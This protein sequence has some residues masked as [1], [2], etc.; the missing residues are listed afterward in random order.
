MARKKSAEELAIEAEIAAAGKSK[1]ELNREASNKVKGTQQDAVPQYPS[2]AA[3]AASGE[4]A[5]ELDAA[6]SEATK[7]KKKMPKWLQSA[8]GRVIAGAVVVV[9]IVAFIGIAT[10]IRMNSTDVWDGTADTSWFKAGTTEYTFH[11]AEQLAGLSK[12]V[13]EG[14]DFDGVQFTL[15]NNIDLYDIPFQCI[16]SGLNN[17]G[18]T[19]KFA[20]SFDGGNHT[21]SGI[22]VEEDTWDHA[23]L[24]GLTDGGVLENLSVEGKVVGQV[25]VGGVVGEANGT[26]VRNCTSRC[27]VSAMKTATSFYPVS[28][29]VGGVIGCWLGIMDEKAEETVDADGNTVKQLVPVELSNLT[30]EGEVSA[31]ACSAGGV[32]GTINNT[33][34]NSLSL[35]N[36]KN[37]GS[38]TVFCEGDEKD[39]GVGGVA[40]IVNSLG[41]LSV[42]RLSNEGDVAC[43]SVYSVGGIFGSFLHEAEFNED[44]MTDPVIGDCTNSGRV[45]ANAAAEI[46][47][48]GGFAGYSVIEGSALGSFKNSGELV[49]T[50]GN[51]SDLVLDGQVEAWEKWEEK[52]ES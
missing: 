45:S 18:Q 28:A 29:D 22:N 14:N 40:G 11:T 33:D 48:V 13:D 2:D 43:S 31:R 8:K 35:N 38:V 50:N 6:L 20:G 15:G 5:P 25:R 51:S 44:E 3:T 34:D 42:S 37:T 47:H 7:E 21:V 41:E 32:I 39:E 16:G 23:G 24:F 36:L 17:Q 30:N 1:K 4:E 19:L 10:L 49:P 9:I 27:E 46:A 12:L 52:N 26:V